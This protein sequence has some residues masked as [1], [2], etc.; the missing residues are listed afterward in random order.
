MDSESPCGERVDVDLG[1]RHRDVRRAVGETVGMG[2][3]GGIERALAG[4]AHL[5]D[6]PVEHVSGREEREAGVV[7]L[8][9]VPAEEVPDPRS[10]VQLGSKRPEIISWYLSVLTC[11]SLNELPME[12]RGRLKLREA[13]SEASSC[14]HVSPVI[15]EQRSA[16]TCSPGSMPCR[17]S[18]LTSEGPGLS[19]AFPPEFQRDVMVPSCLTS[20]PAVQRPAPAGTA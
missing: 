19:R 16:W 17:V 18:V 6:M 13:P 7:M 12:T 14:A 4:G 10:T 15:A 5:L 3:V 20:L 9:V 2:C 8:V 11:A 1:G